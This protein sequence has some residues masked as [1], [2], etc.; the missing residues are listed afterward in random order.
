MAGG[1][2]ATGRRSSLLA[3]GALLALIAS[4]LFW[5]SPSDAQRNESPPVALASVRVTTPADSTAGT[6][7]TAT[8][9]STSFDPDDGN[10]TC[11]GCTLKWEVVTEAYSWIALSSTTTSPATFSVPSP[12]LAARYG[13]S[14]EFK[15]TVTDNDTPAAT[16]S[17]TIT[18]NINQGPTADIAITAMM[19]D[20]AN[21]DVD[22]YD[23]NGN[24]VKDENA[25]KYPL[26][27]VIDGP[28]ENGNA[29]NEWDIAEGSLIILD[30]S[31]SSD[32]NGALPAASHDW[33]RVYIS[34]P[35]AYANDPTASLPGDTADTKRISTDENLEVDATDRSTEIM[36]P[37]VSA[38]ARAG[39]PAPS[40]FVYYRLRVTDTNTLNPATNTAVVKIV[41]H[42]QPKDPVI[43][44]IVPSVTRNADDSADLV[45][46]SG[47]QR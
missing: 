14:I 22:N 43:D 17:I 24:G 39:L 20:P 16:D 44:S 38:T 27:G 3:L 12:A 18:F 36:T 8:L 33:T 21:P 30:G 23:D 31:G 40:Y 11:T 5:A 25:E 32:P 7:A 26:D 28:G 42:D 29:D 2:S 15:L 41:V 47:A 35:D 10:A 13:Q 37:L 46:G 6:P 34:A 19:A 4:V 45:P 1:G 9:T